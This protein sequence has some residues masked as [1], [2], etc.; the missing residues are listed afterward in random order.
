MARGSRRRN[1]MNDDEVQNMLKLVDDW[2]PK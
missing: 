2:N 1:Y